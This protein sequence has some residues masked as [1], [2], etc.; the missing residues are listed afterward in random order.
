M[1][2]HHSEVGIYHCM[3]QG[4]YHRHKN[5]LNKLKS[6]HGHSHVT[7]TDFFLEQTPKTLFY[8]KESRSI[9]SLNISLPNPPLKDFFHPPRI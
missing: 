5:D 4:H 9:F 1:H 2:H 3:S 6:K 8:L 7:M